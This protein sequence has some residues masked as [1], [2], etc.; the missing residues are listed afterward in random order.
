MSD[1]PGE[2]EQMVLLSILQL[3]RDANAL[4][5]RRNLVDRA[6]RPVT[7]GALYRTLDRMA[8]KDLVTFT[9]EVDAEVRGGLPRRVYSVTDEG[10][11]RL[12]QSRRALMNLWDGVEALI[13]GRA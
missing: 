4:S 7:R 9:E 6:G 1:F 3:G 11:L 10:L 12:G 5:I 2:F 13:E 8:R